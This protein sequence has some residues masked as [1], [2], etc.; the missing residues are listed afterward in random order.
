MKSYRNKI[1]PKAFLDDLS[2]NGKNN[3]L[4]DVSNINKIDSLKLKLLSNISFRNNVS[5]GKKLLQSNSLNKAYDLLNYNSNILHQP[6]SRKFVHDFQDLY[7][8]FIVD[9][10]PKQRFERNKDS[11]AYYLNRLKLL[12]YN[13]KL[14]QLKNFKHQKTRNH[15]CTKYQNLKYKSFTY[16]PNH[17]RSFSAHSYKNPSKPYFNYSSCP[18]NF[19][20]I[21][22]DIDSSNCDFKKNYNNTYM[23]R[24]ESNYNNKEFE[25]CFEN[26]NNEKN[27]KFKHKGAHKYDNEIERIREYTK[28]KKFEKFKYERRNNLERQLLDLKTKINLKLI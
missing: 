22:V 7:D 14:T 25:Y 24:S 9:N 2:F 28:D 13:D 6:N 27:Y 20:T 17:W 1:Y 23:K 12:K 26:L 11:V 8:A 5:T 4:K 19:N 10:L 18:T 16:S 3:R 21:N 15:S